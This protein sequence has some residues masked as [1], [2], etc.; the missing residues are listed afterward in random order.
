MSMLAER[1]YISATFLK[2]ICI[3]F[4]EQEEVFMCFGVVTNTFSDS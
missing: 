3:S 4:E 1:M 2:N